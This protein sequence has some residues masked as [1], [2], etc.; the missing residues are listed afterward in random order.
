MSG[1]FVLDESC[2]VGRRGVGVGM[3]FNDLGSEIIV[4]T[5]HQAKHTK[6]YSDLTKQRLGGN[7]KRTT[8]LV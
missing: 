4:N 8:S 1:H 3:R 2:G 6:L 7:S 5:R